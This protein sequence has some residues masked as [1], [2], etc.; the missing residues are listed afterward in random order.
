MKTNSAHVS[1]SVDC[2]KEK[3]E[4][5]KRLDEQVGEERKYKV[6]LNV[7]MKRRTSSR[8]T[9]RVGGGGG[10]KMKDSN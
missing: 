7:I 4:G 2:N 3:Q 6:G 5:E 10:T 1:S 9:Y 8:G